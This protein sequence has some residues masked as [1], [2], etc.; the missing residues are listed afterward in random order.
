MIR[1]LLTITLIVLAPLLL[2]KAAIAETTANHNGQPVQTQPLTMEA[3]LQQLQ[4]GMQN[5]RQLNQ[6]RLLQFR[7]DRA[8]QQEKLRLL[9]QE[10]TAVEKQ[11]RTLEAEF[12]QNSQQLATLNDTL[13]LKLG[14]MKALF[15]S[16]QQVA[17]ETRA[18]FADSLTQ[19]QFPE[20]DGFLKAFSE[21]MGSATRLPDLHELERLWFEL[22]REMVESGKVVRFDTTVNLPDSGQ[23]VE[24]VTRIGLFNLVHN[25]SYLAYAPETGQ[26]VTLPRQ[27]DDRYLDKLSSLDGAQPL[28][29]NIAIDPTRGQLLTMLVDVPGLVD[30]IGQ[31]GAIGYGILALG[32]LALII[33]LERFVSFFWLGRKVNWQLRHRETPVADNPLG[34]LL[35]GFSRYGQ[36]SAEALEL[37]LS[38]ILTHEIPAL[39]RRLVL[40]K[41]IAVITPLMGL[42]GTVTGMIITFQAITLFGTGDPRLMAGGIS[43]ALVTTVLGLTVAI[44]TMLL[45]ALVSGRAKAL[46]QIMEEQAASLITGVSDRPVSATG[47][48]LVKRA[49]NEQPSRRYS[50]EF[51]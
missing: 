40:L 10:V 17:N 16:L 8:L 49:G 22:Q 1:R 20:R 11:G 31:G 6:Q 13:S 38:E 45:H 19:A 5:D 46:A 3:L 29:L 36:H 30:R 4:Q 51:A 18:D 2:S 7:N 43:Q 27:P 24:S 37:G 12:D 47:E 44:P 35:L 33:S 21:K 48:S 41:T 28:P 25:G 9:Q 15:G 26:L 14:A 50:E 39:N 42:L 34:R 23:S 32:L